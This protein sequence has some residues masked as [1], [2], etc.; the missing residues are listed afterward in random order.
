MERIC[1][2]L[3]VHFET[4]LGFTR[5]EQMGCLKAFR[6][7]TN[8]AKHPHNV[9]SHFGFPINILE[10]NKASPG[11]VQKCPKNNQN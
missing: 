11:E 6:D 9:T 5:N 8:G 4:V 2:C 1:E 10:E 7:N 3:Y